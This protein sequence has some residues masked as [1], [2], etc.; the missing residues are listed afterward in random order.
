MRTVIRAT[1][2]TRAKKA[3]TISIQP[4]ISFGG[5]VQRPA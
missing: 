2:P 4:R 3:K 1:A 5:W